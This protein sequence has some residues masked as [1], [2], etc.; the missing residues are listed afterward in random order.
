[1]KISS[2]TECGVR[3]ST[4]ETLS[5]P[6]FNAA[7][8]LSTFG[9]MPLSTMP[10]AFKAGTSLVWRWAITVDGSLGSRIRPGTSLMKTSR[11]AFSAMAAI[12]AATSALQL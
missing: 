3:P 12:A 6:A 5:T 8:A 11:F 10:A 7:T 9:I 4:N 1:V 2:R